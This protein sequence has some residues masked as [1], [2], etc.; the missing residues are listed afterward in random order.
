MPSGDTVRRLRIL[1]LQTPAA[2]GSGAGE[3]T[4]VLRTQHFRKG[5]TMMTSTH[6]KPNAAQRRPLSARWLA[7]IAL[8]AAVASV[9]Q[10][11]H[12]ALAEAWG[13]NGDGELGN[14]TTTN[15]SVPTAVTGLSSGV[16]A[17]AA[18]SGQSLAVQNGGV[19]AWGYNDYGQLGNGTTTNSSVPIAVTGLSSG[20]TAIAGG[21]SHSLAIQNGGAYAWGDNNYGQLGNGTTTNSPTPVAVTGLSSGV[22]AVAGG[23]S[24]SLAVQTGGVYAWGYNSTG[25]LGNGTT[26]NSSTPVVV[27]GLSSGVTAIAAGYAY[28][29]AVQNGGAYAWGFNQF[30]NLGNGT[31]NT[32]T[33]PVA[34]T[35]LSSGVTAISAGYGHGIAVQNGG[36]YAWGEND[37]GQL[38]D[39]TTNNSLTPER[40]DATDLHNIIAVAA[41][42]ES[43]YALSSDGSLWVWGDNGDGELGLGS[44]TGDYLTPQHLLPPS[45]YVFTSISTEIESDDALATLAA[46]PEPRSA[47]LVAVAGGLLLLGRRRRA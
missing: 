6:K 36:V 21:Y 26:N 16:T 28:S 34:V 45:G 14:G 13:A 41:G 33:T 46:V 18:G 20:A 12:A 35:G 27:T 7:R 24:H 15:S 23:N 19:Y 38:G 10:A 2:Q 40:I 30:G 32:S 39:G 11:A 47:G 4:R 8:L 22:T 25:Q 31:T 3:G 44:S 1:A 9:P 29:L 17:I 37:Y 5:A 43:S 42:Y